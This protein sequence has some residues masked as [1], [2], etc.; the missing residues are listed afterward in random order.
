MNEV[1]L[2]ID[3]R[4]VTVPQNTTILEAAGTIGVRIPS[5]CHLKDLSSCSACRICLVEVEG[6][7]SLVTA[8]SYPVSAGIKVK[9]ASERV[10]QARR[11]VMELILSDHPL[12]CMTC[13]KAGNCRLQ[14]L[15]Y[16]M[17][18]S[19]SRFKGERHDYA[20]DISNPFIVRDY[21][22]CVLCER[23]IRICTEVQGSSAIDYAHRGFNTKVAVPYHGGL[24]ESDCVFCGQCV[25]V[26]PV[27]ALTERSRLG[28]GREWEFKKVKTTCVYC[29]VGCTLVLDVKDEQI[30]RVTSDRDS[31]VNGGNMCVK[32]RFGFEFIHHQDRLK[33]PLIKRNGKFKEASWEDAFLLVASKFKEIKTKYGADSLG[34]LASARCTNE[35]NYLMQKFMRAVIGTNNIDHCAR[36]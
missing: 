6:A 32:G 36:L 30:A 1:K 24:Q 3:S 25:S 15:A 23:C 20:T 33:T 4:E 16:E 29:G 19:G 12:D 13:E 18:L 34:G 2:S 10:L 22:K 17:G 21:N 35:E 9:T 7:R 26:C 31:G 28:K 5:L 14:D 27:G 8:C 11:L